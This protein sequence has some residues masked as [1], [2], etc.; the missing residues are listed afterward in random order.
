MIAGDTAPIGCREPAL[1]AVV[2]QTLGQHDELRPLLRDHVSSCLACQ[3]Q[4]HA[5]ERFERGDEPAR[6]ASPVP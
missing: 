4:R 1:G 6:R 2:S 5:F 3:L